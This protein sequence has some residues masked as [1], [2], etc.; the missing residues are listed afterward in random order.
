[1]SKKLA[2]LAK[3]LS[4]PG[5]LTTEETCL[6]KVKAFRNLDA[7]YNK[8]DAAI[9]FKAALN[10]QYNR[11]AGEII[12]KGYV[13]DGLDVQLIFDQGNHSLMQIC[14]ENRVDFNTVI[15]HKEEEYTLLY[16]A[17]RGLV[18]NPKAFE[19]MLHY[20]LG[21]GI[22]INA[23]SSIRKP[24]KLN[25][26]VFPYTLLELVED[27]DPELVDCLLDNGAD[28]SPLLLSLIREEDYTFLERYLSHVPPEYQIP[29]KNTSTVK[30]RKMMDFLLEKNR[31]N[32]SYAYAWGVEDN[33]L[34]LVSTLSSDVSMM[35]SLLSDVKSKEMLELLASKGATVD[36]SLI[37]G[38]K[39]KNMAI[40]KLLIE[41]FN[42]DVNY[43]NDQDQTVLEETLR[44]G[45]FSIA[46][47][48]FDKGGRM[49]PSHIAETLGS[50]I[51][52]NQWGWHRDAHVLRMDKEIAMWIRL[53]H[54]FDKRWM[55]QSFDSKGQYD[56]RIRSEYLILLCIRGQFFRS[57][58]SFLKMDADVT[59]CR[60]VSK[61]KDDS[62]TLVSALSLFWDDP[63]ND[64][65]PRRDHFRTIAWLVFYG[66][67]TQGIPWPELKTFSFACR[68]WIYLYDKVI[69]LL[70]WD[71]TAIEYIYSRSQLC[72]YLTTALP[73]VDIP[74]I[75]KTA[76]KT[77][78][79]FT[80][81]DNSQTD[82]HPAYLFQTGLIAEM[83]REDDD[84]KTVE[85]EEDAMET[86]PL[87]G[88]QLNAINAV[89]QFLWGCYGVQPREWFQDLFQKWTSVELFQL[90]WVANYLMM[91]TFHALLVEHLHQ[92]LQLCESVDDLVDTLGT[93]MLTPKQEQV[94][95]HQTNKVLDKI[96]SKKVFDD[97][98]E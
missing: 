17:C 31:L 62:I 85:G 50:L 53:F 4:A 19:S 11:F 32:L 10:K 90:I 5:C 65:I 73:T 92:R 6:T 24:G 1:M 3:E 14:L 42:G 39:H 56:Q 34:Q 98:D 76:T 68:T 48:I 13:V 28:P 16:Y 97:D 59:V 54:G 88:I 96:P 40:T 86:I 22:D 45:Q 70:S 2:D 38:L 81:D 33:D 12:K 82:Y 18:N 47:V 95:R 64:D 46:K 80:L 69:N 15:P 27:N 72:G 9:L 23:T 49:N 75:G 21:L 35:N 36:A 26:N 7:Y 30:S 52:E 51:L 41:Q 91:E 89:I 71:E 25:Y 61:E 37:F 93:R 78:V 83:L 67:S 66:A 20:C 29:A 94:I 87:P 44:Q 58:R 77:I 60:C 57:L 55:N 74:Y 8:K 63:D 84:E 79:R 43:T